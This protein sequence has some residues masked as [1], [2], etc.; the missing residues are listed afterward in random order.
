MEMLVDPVLQGWVAAWVVEQYERR[1]PDFRSLVEEVLRDD[2]ER[3][4]TNRQLLLKVRRKLLVKAKERRSRALK[5]CKDGAGVKGEDE[6]GAPG[7]SSGDSSGGEG[8]GAAAAAADDPTEGDDVRRRMVQELLP[9]DD[10]FDGEADAG[11]DGELR[12]RLSVSLCLS[13]FL[14][15]TTRRKAGCVRFWNQTELH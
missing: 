4:L 6:D 13:V 15:A 10:G 14:V 12:F 8:G 7:S 11:A 9:G 3:N 2:R 5:A 1:N